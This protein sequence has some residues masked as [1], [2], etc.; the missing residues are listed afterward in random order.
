MY[1]I[2]RDP[3]PGGEVLS[4]FLEISPVLRVDVDFPNDRWKDMIAEVDE[5]FGAGGPEVWDVKPDECD[6]SA[7]RPRGPLG[8]FPEASAESSAA[9]TG[10]PLVVGGIFH[11][12]PATT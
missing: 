12:I 7:D 11:D 4:R 6:V 10:W 9:I 3:L 8:T 1:L 5:C 2:W